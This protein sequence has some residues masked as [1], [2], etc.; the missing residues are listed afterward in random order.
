MSGLLRRGETDAVGVF[1]KP[2]TN[3]N[4]IFMLKNRQI[5]S[6]LLFT[7][8]IITFLILLLLYNYFWVVLPLIV[9]GLVISAIPNLKFKWYKNGYE[10]FIT[11][12]R[13]I[14]G[15]LVGVFLAVHFNHLETQKEN[16]LEVGKILQSTKGNIYACKR[17]MCP[18]IENITDTNGIKNYKKILPYDKILPVSLTEILKMDIVLEYVS[19]TTLERLS[20]S[21]SRVTTLYGYLYD[22]SKSF[23]DFKNI[24][25]EYCHYLDVSFQL[26]ENERLRL[27]NQIGMDSLKT[28]NSKLMPE[29]EFDM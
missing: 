29:Y 5:I 18:V 19:Q 2:L 10:T 12:F 24:G 14:I 16:R 9:I 13:I 28:L 17:M 26:L 23:I 27:T 22:S 3:N 15:T 11:Y 8:S 21:S 7:S 20:I 6:I 25:Y 1:P 4:I